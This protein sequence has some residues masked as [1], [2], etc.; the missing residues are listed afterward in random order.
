MVTGYIT[1]IEN[2]KQQEVCKMCCLL[3]NISLLN[4]IL[5]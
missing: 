2:I 4:S 1:Q 5:T 3:L